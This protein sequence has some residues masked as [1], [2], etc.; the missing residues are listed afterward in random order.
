MPKY[1]IDFGDNPSFNTVLGLSNTTFN[2]ND[3]VSGRMVTEQQLQDTWQRIYDDEQLIDRC[4]RDIILWEAHV[5]LVRL[6]SNTI[7]TKSGWPVTT[8]GGI[9]VSTFD[10][11]VS[12]GVARRGLSYTVTFP[13]KWDNNLYVPRHSSA[14]RVI[15]TFETG[16]LSCDPASVGNDAYYNE[17]Y[18][19]YFYSEDTSL[20]TPTC[21]V[22]TNNRSNFLSTGWYDQINTVSSAMQAKKVNRG[23]IE[24]NKI[25][26]V[27]W[28][29]FIY[30]M[31]DDGTV[32]IRDNRRVDTF[33]I[34]RY[35]TQWTL[36]RCAD[37]TLLSETFGAAQ[38][39]IIDANNASN[40]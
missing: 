14:S 10:E 39:A 18:V 5:Q 3:I 8:A 12:V 25:P 30:D 35:Y 26:L 15:G 21:D 31:K 36:N 24:V 4:C 13:L 40:G 32:T 20:L 16:R 27:E 22:T 19:N 11:N 7:T 1:N 34:I 23:T 9:V 28:F 37:G 2:P 38:Q 17:N 6:N 33:N 29:S